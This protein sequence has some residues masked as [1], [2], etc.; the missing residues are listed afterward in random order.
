MADSCFHK[1]GPL[2]FEGNV[3]ENWR[4]FAQEYDIFIAAAHSN[5]TKKVEAYILLNLAGGEAIERER[6]FCY[7]DEE[8]TLSVL[9]PNLLQ[10]VY[11]RRILRWRNISSTPQF[12]VKKK[13]LSKVG[14]LSDEGPMLETLDY[15]LS[16]LSVHR[17]FYILIS[18]VE[19]V[20]AVVEIVYAQC[21]CSSTTLPCHGNLLVKI[22]PKAK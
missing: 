6:S 17:P 1:P 16:V 2:S 4:K 19:K 10:Y 21:S 11:R 15:I 13:H 7:S 8:N 20:R 9:K 18:N 14:F 12:K 5:E 3:A 22:H